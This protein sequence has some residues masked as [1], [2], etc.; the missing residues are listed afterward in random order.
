VVTPSSDSITQGGN[1]SVVVSV[2]LT[3]GSPATVS[4]SATGV[5]KGLS[6]SFSPTSSQAG[7]VS[8]MGL[9]ISSDL[10][11]GDYP[12]VITAQSTLVSRNTQFDLSVKPSPPAFYTLTV[13]SPMGAGTTNPPSSTYSY[14]PNQPVTITAFPQTGWRLDHW[15]INGAPAGN[16]TS[17]SFL[18]TGDI[19]VQAAFSATKSGLTAGAQTATV[20]ILGSGP[21]PAQVTVDGT[22]SQLPVSFDW[23]AGSTHELSAG[24]P[25]TTGNQS[26]IFFSGWTG[27]VNSTQ[28]TI[29][30]VAK[31]TMQLHAGYQAKDLVVV[32]FLTSGG[33]PVAPSSIVVR[34]PDG[35]QTLA[36][37]NTTYWLNADTKYTLVSADV[38]GVDVSPLNDASSTF[39]VSQPGS[40]TVPLS[41]YPVQ[42][43]FVDLFKQPIKG[44]AV[45]L[46]T[47]GGQTFNVVTG[48][49]GMAYFNTVPFGWYTAKYSYLGLT[50]QIDDT[51]VGSH[52]QTMT[53][54]LSYPL[55]T[56]AAALAVGLVLAWI[57][58]RFRNRGVYAAFDGYSH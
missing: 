31:G 9:V 11:P 19:Q 34:G 27:A 39:V 21:G 2:L 25:Q 20:S 42:L 18:M 23:A 48:S 38:M 33:F 47:E 46:A 4:L 32:H 30:I 24:T 57:R 28:P 36:A 43:A 29:S 13:A 45:T 58:N 10:A 55:F 50:G 17:L 51:T 49:D 44:A 15:L 1:G 37:A 35:F 53:M 12:I 22:P 56:V 5:P 14:P 54:A 6:L 26:R 41:V 7:F 52:A 16:G 8:I 40:L 3:G